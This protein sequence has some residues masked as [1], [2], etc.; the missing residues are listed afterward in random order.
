VGIW[1]VLAVSFLAVA[2][3]LFSR[4]LMPIEARRIWDD[5]LSLNALNPV[6]LHL[7]NRSPFPQNLIV[8]DDVPDEL[9]PDGNKQHVSLPPF[10]A[11]EIRYVLH[12]HQRGRIPLGDIYIRGLALLRMSRWQ[13][14][15]VAGGTARVYPSLFDLRRYD[16]LARAKR[17]QE[18][19]FR[20]LRRL[21]AGR[22][23]ESLRDYLP[24][25]DFR[26]IDWKA[27]ARRGHPITR[28]YELERSQN[29]MLL[30][31]CGRMMAAETEGMTKLDHAINAALMLAHVAVAMDDAV[32][33]I[34]FSDRILRMRFPRKSKDQVAQLANELYE[35]QVEM[36]EPDYT[37]ALAPL[38]GRLRK[39]AL[40]VIFTDLIDL[41][42]SERLVSRTVALYPHHLPLL[43]AI[44]DPELGYL[45]RTPPVRE[46][47][48]YVAAVATRL[49]ERRQMALAAMRQR[50]ALI[51]DVAPHQLT[52]RAVN[53]YLAVKAA[54]RL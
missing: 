48:V 7:R 14:R 32:G 16:Y 44:R 52:T 29:L 50:G 30:L 54:G 33:W 31:D 25:D 11:A 3:S 23:F 37:S 26:D 1:W 5:P 46:E 38:K 22:E 18:V 17:L 39:R 35:L 13:R 43:I 51:L 42:A 20:T 49:T 21:G 24:D 12:P 40:V 9:G 36:V 19:G 4:R 6:R 34:A 27:T 8:Y 28:Q 15:L 53:Q 10:G 41:E 2:D 47:D 45:A